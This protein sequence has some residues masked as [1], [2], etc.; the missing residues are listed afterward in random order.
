MTIAKI[1]MTVIV[2]SASRAFI[3]MMIMMIPTRLIRLAKTSRTPLLR[4]S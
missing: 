3:Y 1:G 2:R 4:I